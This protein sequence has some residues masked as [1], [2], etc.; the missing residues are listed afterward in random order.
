MKKMLLLL[1]AFA[2]TAGVASAQTTTPSTSAKPRS[3]AHQGAWVA[4]SSS[5]PANALPSKLNA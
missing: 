4:A 2:L 3:M 1:T 5:R